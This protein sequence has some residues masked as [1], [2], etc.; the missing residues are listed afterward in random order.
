MAKLMEIHARTRAQ[1]VVALL[2]RCL[3]GFHD[4]LLPQHTMQFCVL[5]RR[6]VAIPAWHR[7]S[8]TNPFDTHGG[9]AM[10]LSSRVMAYQGL[11]EGG[12]RTG[13]PA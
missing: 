12:D 11:Q 9:Q 13:R 3:S 2:S 1:T 5:A 7:P 6:I 10:S 8:G 4:M